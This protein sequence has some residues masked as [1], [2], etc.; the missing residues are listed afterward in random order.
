MIE[1]KFNH[2]QAFNIIDND[3]WV[4]VSKHTKDFN[5]DRF[6]YRVLDEEFDRDTAEFRAALEQARMW[7]SLKNV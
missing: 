4:L 3:G 6:I 2:P 7:R 1:R 5:F